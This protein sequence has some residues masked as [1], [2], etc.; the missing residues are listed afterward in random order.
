MLP[1]GVLLMVSGSW[2]NS[3]EFGM[4]AVASKPWP[5]IEVEEEE[6]QQRILHSCALIGW[7][8]GFFMLLNVFFNVWTAAALW[9]LIY[10]KLPWV[11]E[12]WNQA[13]VATDGFLRKVREESLVD[14]YHRMTKAQRKSMAR[15]D[16]ERLT[17][18]NETEAV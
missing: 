11:R 13:R 6:Q 16:S 10:D 3:G 12:R 15:H 14:Q 2:L 1:L 5:N 4:E 7:I 8:L 18:E 17:K 9:I